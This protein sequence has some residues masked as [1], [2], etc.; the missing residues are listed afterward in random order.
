[1]VVVAIICLRLALIF[2]A[3]FKSF[4]RLSRLPS[5]PRVVCLHLHSRVLSRLLRLLRGLVI[6]GALLLFLRLRVNRLSVSLFRCRTEFC[7]LLR[8]MSCRG[9]ELESLSLMT[10]S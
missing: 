2:L 6:R 10:L 1:M 9:L 8:R 5:L 3:S 7:V 4:L